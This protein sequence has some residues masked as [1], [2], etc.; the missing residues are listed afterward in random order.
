MS[1]RT[2]TAAGRIGPRFA[3]EDRDDVD[4]ILD[5]GKHAAAYI[6]TRLARQVAIIG[7]AV[8]GWQRCDACNPF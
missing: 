7:D 8:N 6:A 3:A 5:C 4:V 1:A 2:V